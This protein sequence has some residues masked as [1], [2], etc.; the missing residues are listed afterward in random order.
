MAYWK[1]MCR[2]SVFFQAMI[3]AAML[4]S[5]AQNQTADKLIKCQNENIELK[6][7]NEKLHKEL[8]AA[9]QTIHQQDQQI[10]NLE[11]LG[12]ARIEQLTRV[13]RIDLDRQTGGYDDNSDRYD[14]GVAVFL[15]P[16]DAKG[17]TIKAAG[18]LRVKLFQLDGDEPKILGQCQYTSDELG[19][20]WVGRFWT[21]HYSVRCPFKTQPTSANITAQ[22]E[23]TE[24]LTGK[25]FVSQKLIEIKL[26]PTTKSTGP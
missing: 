17:H 3:I 22:V 26:L 12:P 14:D 25:P 20:K 21:N 13:D 8:V 7:R 9:Q 18:S 6:D 23:F 15:R 2:W 5:C 11:K 10:K 24:L 4:T 19:K 1:T 16:L